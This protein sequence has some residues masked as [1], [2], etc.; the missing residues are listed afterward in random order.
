MKYL[1]EWIS[2][3]RFFVLFF[4]SLIIAF[5]VEKRADNWQPGAISVEKIQSA[6]WQKE[7]KTDAL[8]DEIERLISENG[9]E[10]FIRKYSQTYF[11]LANSKGISF[12]VYENNKLLYWSNNSIIINPFYP[13]STF[14]G[15]IVHSPNS[16]H[17]VKTKEFGERVIIGL[18]KVRTDYVFENAFLKNKFHKSFGAGLRA[19]ITDEKIEGAEVFGKDGSFLF[20]LEE[21]PVAK[22][23]FLPTISAIFYFLSLVF[24]LLFILKWFRWVVLKTSLNRNLFVLIVSLLLVFLRYLMLHYSMPAI[25]LTLPL[26]E[27]YHYAKSFWFP[28][29]GDFFLNSFFLLFISYLFF[30]EFDYGRLL[31]TGLKPLFCLFLTTFFIT[32]YYLFFH[33]LLSG[34]IL[35]SS[36]LIE[37]YNIFYLNAY[38]LVGYMGIA[39]LLAS[40][41]LFTDKFV[42]IYYG[43]FSFWKFTGLITLF[44]LI[45]FVPFMLTDKV[46]TVYQLIFLLIIV[47]VITYFRMYK[48][49]YSYPNK[50]FIML[51]MALFTC[52]SWLI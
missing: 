51:M 45:V 19:K 52:F 9:P 2:R 43:H 24:F 4:F 48:N 6:I 47:Y 5:L 41:L 8:I 10:E 34:L 30:R 29:L 22:P 25:V 42:S 39:F 11:K 27:P 38:T 3:Y 18:I 37:V 35:N 21:S 13:A 28:S 15:N 46:V 50:V 26:F 32:I 12:V 31:K 23:F 49:K 36:I 17:I 44:I 33:Y 20:S 7:A 16:W 14:K 40:L 1:K